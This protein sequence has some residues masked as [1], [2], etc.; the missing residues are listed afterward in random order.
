M[1]SWLHIEILSSCFLV[2]SI[3]ITYSWAMIIPSCLQGSVRKFSVFSLPQSRACITLLHIPNHQSNRKGK[4]KP[5]GHFETDPYDLIEPVVIVDYEAIPYRV[6]VIHGHFCLRV[7]LRWKQMEI[8]QIW[9]GRNQRTKNMR[10]PFH[11]LHL[12]I[13][14]TKG[15]KQILQLF[16]FRF[17]S[18]S[19]NFGTHPHDFNS[20]L[21]FEIS[22][23]PFRCV[24]KKCRTSSMNNKVN[25]QPLSPDRSR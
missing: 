14:N 2:I 19:L 10:N 8:P 13:V 17:T 25:K 1:K 21:P 12:K 9:T 24:A 20:M 16:H 15:P 7:Q 23:P 11:E 3:E 5:L 6:Q 22:L 4:H 18:L